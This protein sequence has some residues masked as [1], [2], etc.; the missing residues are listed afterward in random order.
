[1]VDDGDF[2]A[3]PDEKVLAADHAEIF[4]EPVA[5]VAQAILR[6]GEPLIRRRGEKVEWKAVLLS[7]AA[8]ANPNM[9]KHGG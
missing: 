6:D 3:A 7:T 4:V 5:G 8:R 1:M 9:L 2:D